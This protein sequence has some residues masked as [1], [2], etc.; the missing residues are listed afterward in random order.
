M[1]PNG[2]TGMGVL[3]I[4]ISVQSRILSRRYRI[5]E[6]AMAGIWLEPLP[7]LRKLRD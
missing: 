4:K 7:F 2:R 3:K 5:S 1:P 6:I